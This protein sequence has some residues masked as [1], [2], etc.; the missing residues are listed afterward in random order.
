MAESEI[1]KIDLGDVPAQLA[2]LQRKLAALNEEQKKVAES[3]GVTSEAYQELNLQIAVTRKE[4]NQTKAVGEAIIAQNKAQT[5]SLTELRAALRQS[6][7]AYANL[8]KAE[9]ENGAEG[10][11]LRET[12]LN[13]RNSLKAAEGATGDF[14]R[15][16]GD[17][18]NA[19][20][21]AGAELL[22]QSPILNTLVTNFKSLT[23]IIKGANLGFKALTGG[24]TTAGFAIRAA[25]LGPILLLIA[26]GAGIVAFFTRTKEGSDKFS[27]GL[28]FLQGVFSGLIKIVADFGKVIID[29]LS[30]PEKLLDLLVSQFSNRLQ[31]LVDALTSF[32]E[33]I[34]GVF[35]LDKERAAQGLR[36]FGKA[37][38]TILSGLS[39][40]A[41]N[42]IGDTLLA[43]G[44]AYLE[45]EKRIQAVEKRQRELLKINAILKN[46][47]EKLDK[48][49]DN[50]NLTFTEREAAAQK[51]IQ[52]QTQLNKNNIAVIKE[53]IAIAKIRQQVDG[54]TTANLEEIAKLEGEIVSAVQEG[55]TKIFD[56]QN[57]LS[58]IRISERQA[59]LNDEKAAIE[60]KLIDVKKFSDEELKLRQDL[61][62]K[63][64]E[65]EASAAGL[66]EDQRTNIINKGIEEQKAL[67][68]Q[69]RIDKAKADIEA[70]NLALDKELQEVE[71][72]TFERLELEKQ[73]NNIKLNNALALID[74]EVK[75][76][77]EKE[78]AKAKIR[79]D[80]KKTQDEL[81]KQIADKLK[82][83]IE[84][85]T[86]NELARLK[87]L[88]ENEQAEL[89]TRLDAQFE[90]LELEKQQRIEA[91]KTTGESIANIEEE[92]RQ[93]SLKQT[94]DAEQQKQDVA[95]K[96]AQATFGFLSQLSDLAYQA[97]L[98]AAG[99][100]AEEKA[101]I[102]AAYAKRQKRLKLFEITLNQ[103]AAI[104]KSLADTPT[105]ANFA[106]AVS[107]GAQIAALIG[108]VAALQFNKGG[109][110]P[111]VGN[112]DTV[113][114]I[115][116][117]GE[118]VI[119]KRAA[120]KNLGLLDS[121]NRS[122]GGAPLI[123]QRLNTGGIVLPVN[124]GASGLSTEDL[125]A[126][127]NQ[128]PTPVVSVQQINRAQRNNV[129]VRQTATL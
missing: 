29:A 12:L 108:Q 124:N 47:V 22:N 8:S 3:S 23:T 39:K 102:D 16:V 19:V 101:R 125:I 99:D 53:Q 64:A 116:T 49:S 54:E 98:A 123:P 97:D 100:N 83:E 21:E 129:E 7:I 4:I 15:N 119:N 32:G 104:A 82:K 94:K 35:T 78:N 28:A 85:E 63:N 91:A 120:E 109:R 93:R 127:F 48:A 77:Q 92:F 42:A 55:N 87:L 118:V 5:G 52:K 117:P 122:T 1:L 2:D 114:A 89:Q 57:K 50:A 56:L 79:S 45:T 46:D 113:P 81:D 31:G 25:L 88:T 61:V 128:L 20:R 65:I 70:V 44:N 126:A 75:S 30:S 41:Q 51:A 62:A 9:R 24:A 18:K 60:T 76:E 33:V 106:F 90:L 37:Q 107:V 36:D 73:A 71:A 112:T 72:G 27:Q 69:F 111:G 103:S 86:N 110:V 96:D 66:T 68:N 10:K 11:R 6:E 115:L 38:I 105:P 13:L 43:S 80:F 67:A 84:T 58:N 95:L 59:D 17:Y 121:I 34:A 26:A 40:E 74:L 14:R